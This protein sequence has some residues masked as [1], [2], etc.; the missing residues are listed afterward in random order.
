MI[1]YSIVLYHIISYRTIS[2]HISY[3]ILSYWMQ[4]FPNIFIFIPGLLHGLLPCWNRMRW[5]TRT[6]M[7]KQRLF[8]DKAACHYLKLCNHT[9]H[10]NSWRKYQGNLKPN[11]NVS[12]PENWSENALLECLPQCGEFNWKRGNDLAIIYIYCHGNRICKLAM[13]HKLQLRVNL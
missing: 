7:F 6:S 11:T 10:L 2:Y 4:N 5:R 13:R 3:H 8:A 9:V 1:T 12:H